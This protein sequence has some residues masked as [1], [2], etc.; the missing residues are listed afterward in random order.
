MHQNPV[1]RDMALTGRPSGGVKA[2]DR[3]A[4]TTPLSLPVR[5]DTLLGAVIT[6][7]LW[8][9]TREKVAVDPEHPDRWSGLI[10]RPAEFGARAATLLCA[11]LTGWDGDQ[12]AIRPARAQIGRRRRAAWSA[13]ADRECL[14]T[15]NERAAGEGVVSAGAPGVSPDRE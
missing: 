14:Q 7:P 1:I 2:A 6:V 8:V 15:V 11:D 3:K 10:D 9:L 13:E 12:A 5:A 4:R